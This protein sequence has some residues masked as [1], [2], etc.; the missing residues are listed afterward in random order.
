MNKMRLFYLFTIIFFFMSCK[1]D[2]SGFQNHNKERI[3]LSGWW[4]YGEGFHSFMD[5]ETLDEFSL[6]FLN[7]DS[8][9]IIDL[10]LSVTEMEYFP[11]E[12]KISG[13]KKSEIFMVD[14]FE[15]T[16]IVGCDEQ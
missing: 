10:Y 9:E 4:I 5:E 3:D 6:Q 13:Y 7:E 1:M 12:T 11:M 2:N 15:I 8:V 14:D 16:Y